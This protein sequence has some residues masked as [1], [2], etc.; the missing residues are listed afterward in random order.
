MSTAKI[1]AACDAPTAFARLVPRAPDVR[2]TFDA[3]D[4]LVRVHCVGRGVLHL[5]PVAIPAIETG[6]TLSIMLPT[7][8]SRAFA[9]AADYA[10]RYGEATPFAYDT[11]SWA[12]PAGAVPQLVIAWAQPR[13]GDGHVDI[14][15]TGRRPR[16][17]AVARRPRLVPSPRPPEPS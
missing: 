14:T 10:R 1:I 12:V 9:L 11:A 15:L 4:R 16:P 17:L 5:L 13:R 3:D 6:M 7:W 8:L 2:L